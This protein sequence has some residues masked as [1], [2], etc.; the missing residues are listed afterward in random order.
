MMFSRPQRFAW[1]ALDDQQREDLYTA[2][3]QFDSYDEDG[4]GLL[5]E[6]EFEELHSDL[7]AAGYDVRR[8]RDDFDDL[9]LDKSGKASF[10]EYANWIIRRNFPNGLSLAGKGL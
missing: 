5:S 2:L 9:D 3:D 7:Q 6:A 10:N 4:D 8:L 1:L